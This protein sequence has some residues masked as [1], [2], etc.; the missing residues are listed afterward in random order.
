MRYHIT[1]FFK[2]GRIK[3]SDIDVIH[4]IDK[5]IDD[6]LLIAEMINDFTKEYDQSYCYGL[7]IGISEEST[8]VE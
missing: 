5:Y 2:D 3:N 7:S 8:L 4:S 6:A 1:G